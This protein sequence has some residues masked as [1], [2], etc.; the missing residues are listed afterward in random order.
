MS[1][2]IRVFLLFVLLFFTTPLKADNISDFEIEGMSIGD[3][4]LDYMSKEEIKKKMN[5]KSSF[6]YKTNAYVSI[7]IKSDNFKVYDEIG[8]VI[9]PTDNN[10]IMHSIEGTFNYN[11][12]INECYKKQ[13]IITSDLKDMFYDD[14]KFNTFTRE[15]S[16]DKSGKSTS[17]YNDFVFPDDSAIRVICY[18]MNKDFIDPNDQLYLA[19]VSKQFMKWLNNN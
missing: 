1:V 11:D 13:N 10:F 4:L 14:A 5:A 2:L 17:K 3:S 9:E 19:I 8:I 6:W 12:N 18:D 16:A 7:L 15:Y